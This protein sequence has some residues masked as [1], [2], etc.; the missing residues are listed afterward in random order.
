MNQWLYFCSSDILRMRYPLLLLTILSALILSCSQTT[1]KESINSYEDV[2]IVGAM[3]NVMW[4]GELGSSIDLDTI[5]V[6]QGL[7]GLGPLTYLAGELMLKDGISYVSR[8]TSDSTMT[9]EETF[10][11]SAPFFVYTHVNKWQEIEVPISV[12]T[13]DDLE[14]FVEEKSKGFKAPFAFQVEGKINKGTIHIQNLPL[15]TKISSPK[16]AHQGQTNYPIE[17]VSMHIVGFF[18]KEHKGIFTHHD[19]N[20]HLH[21]I[22]ADKKKM[23]H[24]DEAEF[25]KIKLLL[26]LG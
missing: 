13:I 17:H 12:K 19:S 26:P 3:K 4:K 8:A 25:G 18:S 20:V 9:V 24:L 21:L 23:G 2:H 22:T 11:V 10:E 5:S 14:A 1:Q 15:G 6:K 16:E 7:Y